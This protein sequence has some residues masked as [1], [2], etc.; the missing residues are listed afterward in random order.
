MAFFRPTVTGHVGCTPWGN[1][2]T[3][4]NSYDRNDPIELHQSPYQSYTEYSAV[5]ANQTKP[6]NWGLIESFNEYSRNVLA[7]HRQPGQLDIQWLNVFPSTILR[8]DGH[9]GF[10]D[11]L[12][13]SLPGPTDWWAHLFFSMLLDDANGQ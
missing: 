12:H 8:R 2:A 5:W 4:L 3:D 9:V 11:C 6:Y 10:G 13:Y 7:H 1:I